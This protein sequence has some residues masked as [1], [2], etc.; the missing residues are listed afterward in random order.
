MTVSA[1][2]A[3]EKLS[4]TVLVVPT[5]VAPVAGKEEDRAGAASF[6]VACS[7]VSPAR[8]S[9]GWVTKR[10]TPLEEAQKE[11]VPEVGGRVS[12]VAGG[13]HPLKLVT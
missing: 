4:T 9:D 3:S 10:R 13:R 11:T 6:G 2:P 8:Q 12:W 5:L 1:P 7:G